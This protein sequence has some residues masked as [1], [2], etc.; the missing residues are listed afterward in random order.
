MTGSR[1]LVGLASVFAGVAAL[2]LVVASAY[3]TPVPLA[4][5]LP[6]GV[7]G[8]LLWYQGT[9]RLAARI[10]ERA[11]RPDGRTHTRTR[12]GPRGR[13]RTNRTRPPRQPPAGPTRR[14]AYRTLG[15]EPGAERSEIRRAYREKVKATHPDSGGDEAAFKEVTSAYERLS[16]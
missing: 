1:L 14:E 7:T 5:A 4:I 3:R 2:M 11:R 12:T 9:G 6:F 15:L 16:E 8:Y 10:R 13:T